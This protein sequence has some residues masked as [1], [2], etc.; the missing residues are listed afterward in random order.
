MG[1]LQL[2]TPAGRPGSL[3]HTHTHT[4]THTQ[5]RTLRRQ[6]KREISHLK[7]R[8]KKTP[9]TPTLRFTETT[10]AAQLGERLPGSPAVAEPLSRAPLLTR[11]CRSDRP[12]PGEDGTRRSGT[13]VVPGL[14]YRLVH[15]AS[16][17]LLGLLSQDARTRPPAPSGTSSLL[18]KFWKPH[19][20]ESR[21]RGGTG[22][23]AGD[24]GV[25]LA[26]GLEGSK[27]L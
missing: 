18:E 15:E 27:L 8:K 5:P 26:A 3:S 10:W 19:V 20:Q 23:S 4:H 16:D 13:S 7:N 25:R 9:K 22:R 17:F 2:S 24:R 21:G 11:R 6:R 12:G 1:S 14:R